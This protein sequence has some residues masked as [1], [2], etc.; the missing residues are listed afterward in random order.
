MMTTRTTD[1]LSVTNV[2]P[3]ALGYALRVVV[4]VE[5]CRDCG[6]EM[7]VSEMSRRGDAYVCFGCGMYEREMALAEMEA[8]RDD[9]DPSG[10][11]IEGG[12]RSW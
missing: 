3:V 9:N 8:D 4:R 12:D 7:D 10:D 2:I 5:T 1:A 6:D 11:A